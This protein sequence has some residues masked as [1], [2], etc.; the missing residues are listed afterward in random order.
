[1][2]EFATHAEYRF[3]V[4]EALEELAAA[5]FLILPVHRP[6]FE[7][8]PDDDFSD[9][10][11]GCSCWNKNCKVNGKHPL[12]PNYAR[13]ATR[14]MVVLQAW[15][16]DAGRYWPHLDFMGRPNWAVLTGAGSGVAVYDRDPKNG[17]EESHQRLERLLGP[18]PATVTVA[19]GSHVPGAVHHYFR[20][21]PRLSSDLTGLLGSGIDILAGGGRYA[22]AP[23][24]RHMSGFRYEWIRRPSEVPLADFPPLWLEYIAEQA[25][26]RE[27]ERARR[28]YARPVTGAVTEEDYAV[29]AAVHS[30]NLA[31]TEA[32]P[33]RRGPCPMCGSPDG[34][35]LLDPGDD[36]SKSPRWDCKST[37]HQAMA[38][39][40]GRQNRDGSFSGTQ[41]DIDSFTMGKPKRTLLR[42]GLYLK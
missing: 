17:S 14:N 33:K 16:S 37:R 19:S 41:L 23:P 15:F 27:K 6:R 3:Y 11:V 10:L 30:Y 4:M 32:W 9:R 8:D 22:V 24:S 1:M 35:L 28:T 20:Y 25:A 31:N 18:L 40:P 38:L 26:R 13:W 5:G 39:P 12:P 29:Y 2:R 21:T 36:K 42:A 34:F 7:R